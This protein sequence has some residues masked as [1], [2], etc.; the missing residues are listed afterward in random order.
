[1][2]LHE[3]LF[4]ACGYNIRS[5]RGP[6]ISKRYGVAVR[7]VAV[8]VDVLVPIFGGHRFVE[9][10]IIISIQHSGTTEQHAEHFGRT[11]IQPDTIGLLQ[12]GDKT[13][14]FVCVSPMV[15]MAV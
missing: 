3:A 8:G 10:K 5:E 15:H 13:V 12:Q 9:Q 2:F 14:Q 7:N 11:D 1:M 4:H 6:A